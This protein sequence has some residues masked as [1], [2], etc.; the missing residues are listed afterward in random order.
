M[1]FLLVQIQGA[2][3]MAAS[4]PIGYSFCYNLLRSNN[5]NNVNNILILNIAIPPIVQIF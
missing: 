2:R 3:G 5:S 4:K 1:I